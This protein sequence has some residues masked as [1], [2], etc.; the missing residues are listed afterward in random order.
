M[1]VVRVINA[2]I[3]SGFPCPVEVIV[4]ALEI[5]GRSFLLASELVPFI[6]GGVTLS[7]GC[8]ELHDLHAEFRAF[9]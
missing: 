8:V 6:G 2:K 3:P 5:P 9:V 1:A 4:S 7:H